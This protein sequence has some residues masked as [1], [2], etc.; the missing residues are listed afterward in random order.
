MTSE[1]FRTPDAAPGGLFRVTP[2][3]RLLFF[4]TIDA[5]LI[6]GSIVAA[7]ALRFDGMIPAGYV[8]EMAFLAGVAI[9]CNATCLYILGVY[10][11]SWSFMSLRDIMLVGVSSVIATFVLSVI[12][13][14]YH[15]SSPLTTFPRSVILIQFPISFL[16][17]AGFRLTRRFQRIV[18]HRR[19]RG[20]DGASTL[21]IGAGTSGVQIVSSILETSMR[22][23]YHVVG[24]L[25][26]DPL[27]KGT[28]IQGVRVLGPVADLPRQVA[29]FGVET[30]I[31]CIATANSALVTRLVDQCRQLGVRNIRIVPPVSQIVTGKLTI[32]STHE[33]GLEDLLGRDQVTISDQDL[34]GLLRGKPILVTGGAGTI[35][36]ELCR[37][38]CRHHPERLIVL[39][40]DETRLHDAVLEL[41]A[42]HPDV[43]VVPALLDIRQNK[44]LRALMHEHRP[45]T[46]FHAAAFKHVSM[47]EVRPLAAIQV[48]ALG[49]ME[50]I[51]AAADAGAER[52]VL[53]STD[54]AV[55]PTGVM[56]ASKRLAEFL[57]LS[58]GARAGN[59]RRVAVRFG[60][61]IGSR[62]SV[63]PIFERQLK[64]GGPLTVT[65]PEVERFF[66]MT[67]EAVALVLQAAALGE[68]GDLFVLDMGKPVRILDVAREFIRLH[69]LRP[70][71]DMPIE[72][73]GL[74]K[75]EKLREELH[76]PD[77]KL[78]PTSHPKIMRTSVAKA[79][80]D[81]PRNLQEL[82]R[83]GDPAQATLFL[84]Q[85]FP[86]LGEGTEGLRP[87]GTTQTARKGS[88]E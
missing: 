74:R 73:I 53:I 71:V 63:I 24:F 59:L 15:A 65:H 52:F 27:A 31:I 7:M 34:G 56:G 22:Q 55:H 28:V 5:V 61:V 67:S 32:Q 26:D 10:R 25:D 78:L 45:S 80:S 84:K 19:V 82:A 43:L 12:A 33:V 40:I 48:N 30:V 44:E 72:I 86:T 41:G 49:T 46:V 38:I 79:P 77:E 83:R 39:D 42:A 81:L 87:L 11:V 62:G 57:A 66:M 36:L 14:F 20:S 23:Q 54:K 6:A 85:L 47:M 76:H 17:L 64:A 68:D 75:G 4:L 1:P 8:K 16:A 51:E 60:N 29:H 37:Q 50:V 2:F 58:S 35:G 21:I 3:R 18:R 9:V 88:R 69:G 13:F 70:E